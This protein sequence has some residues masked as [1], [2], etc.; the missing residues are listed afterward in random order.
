MFS[1]VLASRAEM[2]GPQFFIRQLWLIMEAGGAGGF[3]K[4]VFRV[5]VSL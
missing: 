2:A 1:L 5:P 3:L 4:G